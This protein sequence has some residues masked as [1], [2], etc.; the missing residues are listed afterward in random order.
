MSMTI[1]SGNGL[2]ELLELSN[3]PRKSI[4]FAYY[5]GGELEKDGIET[6]SLVQG[7]VVNFNNLS[8]I[9]GGENSALGFPASVEYSTW[10]K[11]KTLFE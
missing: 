5:N 2:N 6:Q 3:C 1:P 10:Y 11:I 9:V 8:T 7:I 4:T